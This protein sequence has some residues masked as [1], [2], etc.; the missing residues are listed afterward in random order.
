MEIH[1]LPRAEL[2][3]EGGLDRVQYLYLRRA[4]H[5][6]VRLPFKRHLP[7]GVTFYAGSQFWCLSLEHC[8]YVLAESI[9][10]TPFFRRALIPDEVFFHTIL[11]NSTFS[12]DLINEDITYAQWESDAASPS[13]LGTK[14]IKALLRSDC[15]FARKFDIDHDRHILDELDGRLQ[16]DRAN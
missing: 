11:M 10:W 16:A 8:R 14:D 2:G 12:K 13:L 15:Y 3:A 7:E 1:R 4:R 5:F 9:K 6:A